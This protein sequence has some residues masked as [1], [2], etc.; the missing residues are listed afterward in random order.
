M[1]RSPARFRTAG[2][3]P[4]PN[5]PCHIPPP[6]FQAGFSS[7]DVEVSRKIQDSLS[8]AESLKELLVRLRPLTSPDFHAGL[9]EA[10]AAAEAETGGSISLDGASAGYKK[11]ADKVKKLAQEHKLPWQTLVSYKTKV[12]SADE[13]RGWLGVKDGWWWERWLGFKD[14]WWSEG[15]LG[16]KDGWWWERWLGFK[17]GWWWERWLMAGGGR[18]G[19]G[20]RM[21][22]GGRGGWGLRMGGGGRGGW[23]LRMAGGGS[24]GWGLR[25]AGS[26]R[27]GWGLRMASGE[28]YGRV[29]RIAGGGRVGWGSRMAAAVR[30]E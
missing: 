22:G 12:A 2:Y 20:L 16:F 27:G 7:P 23:G 8:G 10:L 24:G 21:A 18:S 30:A 5:T 28:R 29:L 17:D 19:W 25:M 11:F 1:W 9:L 6:P 3:T 26:R 13:V 14:G 15:W 4:F